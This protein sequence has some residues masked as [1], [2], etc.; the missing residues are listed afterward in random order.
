GR[1]GNATMA[2]ATVAV[3]LNYL[4][5]AL[6]WAAGQKLLPACPAFPEVRVPEKT[7]GPVPAETVERLLDRARAEGDAQMVAFLL[8]GWR[9]GLRLSEAMELER[10]ESAEWPWVDFARGRIVLPAAFVK[11]NRDQWVPLDA[12]LREALLALPDRGR[13]VF[14]FRSRKSGQAGE[15]TVS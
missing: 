13:K 1:G 8:C 14:H 7:P 5:I 6:Q 3:Y 9:A 12:E 11:G 15:T 10:Q 2:P 4:H